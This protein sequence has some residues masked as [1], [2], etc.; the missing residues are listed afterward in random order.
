MSHVLPTGSGPLATTRVYASGIC[1][2][3][4]VPLIERL[5]KPLPGVVQVP[6]C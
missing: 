5:L 2:P 3:M 4:E 1:C 6:M